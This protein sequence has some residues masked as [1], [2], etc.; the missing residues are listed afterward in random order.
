MAGDI[1]AFLKMAAE[2]RRQAQAGQTQAGQAG[3]AQAGQAQ[4]DQG[5]GQSRPS[6]GGQNPG[7]GN[8]G[9]ATRYRGQASGRGG[10]EGREASGLG[11]QRGNQAAEPERRPLRSSLSGER[12]GMDSVQLND[13]ALDPYAQA[14][15]LPDRPKSGQGKAK[16]KSPK[17]P[18]PTEGGRLKSSVAPNAASSAGGSAGSASETHDS[19]RRAGREG[20]ISDEIVR[21]LQTPASI[22]A[23]IV[24]SEILR[25]RDFDRDD[26]D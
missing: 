6:Q 13:V 18:A 22:P 23:A 24:L 7:G 15:D 25:P 10:N 17:K 4:A 11:G 8:S 3:Q 26:W 9:P 16:A 1:E 19:M 2:R 20:G 5:Q 21:M 14:D 12:D